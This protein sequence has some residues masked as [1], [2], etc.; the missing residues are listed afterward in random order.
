MKT[1]KTKMSAKAAELKAMKKE[2]KI[3]EKLSETLS[4]TKSEVK[5]FGN[6]KAVSMAHE[7]ITNRLWELGHD[8]ED[9]EEDLKY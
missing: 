5:T 9:G 3:L 2:Q 1:T 4:K 8:I 7:A 6:A